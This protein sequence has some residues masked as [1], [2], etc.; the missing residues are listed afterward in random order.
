MTSRELKR[1]Q[2]KH[3]AEIG[4]Y[5]ELSESDDYNNDLNRAII[6]AYKQENGRCFMGCINFYDQKRK[7]IASGKISCYEEYTGQE[8]Y[9]FACAFI[10]PEADAALARLITEW[11]KDGACAAII[12]DIF[13]RIEELDG[14]HFIWT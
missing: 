4:G 10:V 13:N 12:N 1:E 9:N 11:N 5:L 8:I 7:D 14:L 3:I 6:K 2:Y